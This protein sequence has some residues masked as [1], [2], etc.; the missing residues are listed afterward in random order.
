MIQAT[1]VQAMEDAVVATLIQLIV[2][3]LAAR[4]AG[5]A[6]R[7]LRQ[8]RAVG[9]IVAGL[10]LGP[11]LLG[12]LFPAV[13]SAVFANVAAPVM[14]ILSQIG[15]A[16]LMF[17]IGITFEFGLLRHGRNKRAVA[18][19]A[20]ASIGAPLATGLGV[21][22]LTAPFMTDDGHA[23]VYTLFVAV[24][25]AI[26]AVPVLGRIL[27]EYALTHTETGVVAISA[28][29]ANDVVGWVLLAG[30][31]AYASSAFSPAHFA[32]QI[33][34]LAIL[35]LVFAWVGPPL[36]DRLMRKLPIVQG[37]L[38]GTLLAVVLAG[39][40]AAGIC[41]QKLGIFVIFGGFLLGL[42]FHRHVA[43]VQAWHRQVG[44]FVLVFFLPIF[45]TYTGL[46]TNILGLDSAAK[47]AVC[48]GIVLAAT[49]AKFVP[50]YVAS[51]LAG[52]QPHEARILG[53][54]MNTRALMELIVLNIGFSLGFI[55][56]DM[57]TMLVIMAVAT[58]VMTGP[59][60]QSLLRA[61]GYRRG[62]L[63]DA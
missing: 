3:V 8:P 37:E 38:P 49:L 18:F 47:W 6:A 52:V 61:T 12:A 19:V 11:S 7:A 13:S 34:G 53:V 10:L 45:F 41:T 22:W 14:Q 59:L 43:F 29:A 50:V 55:P 35:F 21:G 48:L 4:V 63:V 40:F 2:I 42:L 1:A 31:A 46:R 28:A 17:Q 44:Q 54:L 26:T 23:L 32:G 51:R 27:R 57:F 20:V 36:V 39:I 60:L 15:L 5:G 16:L 62:A 9:E 25:F 33:S 30:V 58:T 56:Q 24:A